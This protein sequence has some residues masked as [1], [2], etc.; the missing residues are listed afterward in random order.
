MK[1]AALSFTFFLYFQFFA[2]N[3]CNFTLHKGPWDCWIGQWA[4]ITTGTIHLGARSLFGGTQKR[5]YLVYFDH[6]LVNNMSELERDETCI[7]LSFDTLS[8]ARETEF[9]VIHW[10][11]L[12]EM[13][14][15]KSFLTQRTFQ[16]WIRCWCGSSCCVVTFKRKKNKSP[17]SVS[18][19]LPRYHLITNQ[20]M[21]QDL[22]QKVVERLRLDLMHCWLE[23]EGRHL[24]WLGHLLAEPLMMSPLYLKHVVSQMIFVRSSLKLR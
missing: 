21:A 18:I 12:Y 10:W 1:F 5:I 3:G 11:T 8:T 16:C 6:L 9:V 19:E 20:L 15:F 4:L 23:S 22:Q 14:V 13:S 24:N 2:Q 17:R 7:Y